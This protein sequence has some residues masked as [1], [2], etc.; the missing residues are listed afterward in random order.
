MTVFSVI[1]RLSSIEAYCNLILRNA[2]PDALAEVTGRKTG[3]TLGEM[4]ETA[5]D[6]CRETGA[7]LME[8]YHGAGVSKFTK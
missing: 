8:E 2:S 1:D 7:Q 6:I 4:V 3:R 5:R